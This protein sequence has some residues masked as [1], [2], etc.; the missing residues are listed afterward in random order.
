MSYKELTGNLFA[1]KAQALVNT[2]NCVGPMGKGIALEFRRRFPEMFEAY[3]R[4]CERGELRPGQIL[5]YR[6]SQPWVLNLAVKDDWKHPSRVE[7]VEQCLEKF[8]E[9][10]PKTGLKSV[11]FPWMGAM[12]GRIPLDQIKA[13]TRR[14]LGPLTDI[15]VEVYTFDPRAPDPLFLLLKKFVAEH[16]PSEFASAAGLRRP[17]AEEIFALVDNPATTS[18]AII[19]EQSRLGKTSLDRLYGFLTEQANRSQDSSN[20][21][22]SPTQLDLSFTT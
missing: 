3:R 9:W 22:P 13:V 19:S 2:V 20:A 17:F 16:A 21:S 5:P 1:S 8:C 11:A 6:K 12:N 10:Y 14:F 18:L 4:V 15:D 7:W